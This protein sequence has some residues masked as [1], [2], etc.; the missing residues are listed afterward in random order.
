MLFLRADLSDV[1]SKAGETRHEMDML[2]STLGT[3]EPHAATSDE[4]CSNSQRVE[5]TTASQTAHLPLALNSSQQMMNA[6][7][8]L[9]SVSERSIVSCAKSDYTFVSAGGNCLVSESSI[10][11]SINQNGSVERPVSTQSDLDRSILMTNALSTSTPLDTDESTVA[12][13]VPSSSACIVNMEQQFVADNYSLAHGEF[14][15]L[16]PAAVCLSVR[17]SHF[18][19]GYRVY[20]HPAAIGTRQGGSMLCRV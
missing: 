1:L 10:V 18:L 12:R 6:E 11:D 16:P 13:V 17:L 19:G 7:S 9:P 5:P 8:G 14:I 20:L 4:P 15:T 3:S 2:L